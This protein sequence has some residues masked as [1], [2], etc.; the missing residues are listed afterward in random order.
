[1]NCLIRTNACMHHT[2]KAIFTLYR[3][4]IQYINS[5]DPAKIIKHID[6]LKYEYYYCEIVV[7]SGYYRRDSNSRWGMSEK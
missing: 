7:G 1:M 5:T 2:I 3:N 6:P 4:I